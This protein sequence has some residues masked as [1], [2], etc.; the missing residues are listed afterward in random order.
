MLAS[1]PN[2]CG[3][4]IKICG[5]KLNF[6]NLFFYIFKAYWIISIITS[7]KFDFILCLKVIDELLMTHYVSINYYVMDMSLYPSPPPSFE[8]VI[9][10][11]WPNWLYFYCSLKKFISSFKVYVPI[12]NNL[13]KYSSQQNNVHK[14]KSLCHFA[15]F[16]DILLR[17]PNLFVAHL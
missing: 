10:V 2:V 17:E 4:Q 15:T 3:C 14:L 9:W 16:Q 11:F 5:I 13:C 12:G 1:V 8:K 6:I 7:L